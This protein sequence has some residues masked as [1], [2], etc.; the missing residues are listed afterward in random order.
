MSDLLRQMFPEKDYPGYQLRPLPPDH[1]V[2]TVIRQRWKQLPRLQGASDDSRT[3]FIVSQEYLSGD[4]QMNRTG[5][6]AFKLATNLLFYAT[7]LG[8]LDGKFASILPD[9]PAAPARSTAITVARVQHSV[10]AEAPR[11]WDAAAACWQ[12]ITPYVRHVTG[13]ELNE[14]QPVV[15]G[16]DPLDGIRL[17]HVTGRTPAEWTAGELAALKR[18]VE[19]GG[20][21]LVD[22]WAGSSPFADSTRS[23]LEAAFG[24]LEP[25]PAE[26]LLASGLFQGG[27]DLADAQFKLEARR[28][29]RSRGQTPRGQRLLV[30]MVGRRPAVIY[31]E[32]DL[33]S[34][35]AGIA[36]Y[37]ALG[38][39]PKSARR[40]IGNLMA[41]LD[42]KRG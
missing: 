7:D 34:A 8:T 38:Y 27:V 26:H 39:Q 33:C 37:R 18:Y 19:Q 40:I 28:L 4:W 25:L 12:M 22:A 13:G 23:Q 9:S 42:Q 16:R 14:A 35:M 15:L 1:D 17:L 41:Y 30:A 29:L 2:L 21:V 31:S 3:F 11:D 32:F 6:D 10:T 24:R 20:T 36:S 5:S